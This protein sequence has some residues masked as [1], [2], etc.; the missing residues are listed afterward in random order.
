VKYA[1]ALV[2]LMA[3]VF[4]FCGRETEYHQRI[5]IDSERDTSILMNVSDTLQVMA[6][7]PINPAVWWEYALSDTT[8]IDCIRHSSTPLDTGS[9]QEQWEFYMI[10]AGKGN[11][12]FSFTGNA[13]DTIKEFII[14]I[15]IRSGSISKR[16]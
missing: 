1:I 9:Y 8:L 7:A 15:E 2:T 3:A 10:K 16:M 14:Q 11:V 13:G 12:L 5:T 6:T 4:V